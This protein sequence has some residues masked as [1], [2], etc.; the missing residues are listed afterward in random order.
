[1][2]IKDA[3]T[4]FSIE[5]MEIVLE[6]HKYGKCN[7]IVYKFLQILKNSYYVF[8]D[9]KIPLDY[10]PTSTN[11][12]RYIFMYIFDFILYEI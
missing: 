2:D 6:K 10:L 4:S 5:M 7:Y 12:S 11:S 1:M 9:V 8:D 3:F